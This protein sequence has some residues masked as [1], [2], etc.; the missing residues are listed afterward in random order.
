MVVIGGITRLTG[1]GLSITEWNVIM[2]A[3]PP[4]NA[5]Q[6]Q[7]A[8][9]KYKTIPQ[10]QLI[11][12]HFTLEEFKSIFMWEYL[13]RLIGRLLGVVFLVPFI[14]FL[15]TKKLD[16]KMIRKS[17][18]LF[19]LGG[20][21]GFLGWYM[22]SSGLT[23]RTSVSHYRLAVHLITAFITYG[24]TF[25]FALELIYSRESG[26]GSREKKSALSSLAKLISATVV[27]QI[28]YGAFVAGLH[29]GQIANT[30]PT[31]DGAWVPEGLASM[32]PGLKN[33]FENLL[34]VQFIHRT[35]AV[36]VVALSVW[37]FIA[38][39]KHQLNTSQNK[40]ISFLLFAISVQFVLGVLTLLTKVQIALAAF[41]Q[42]GAFMLFS[43]CVFLLFQFRRTAKV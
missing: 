15:I 11:N 31:M 13:H 33:L 6:W 19:A 8:F 24:F 22:V 27:L 25:W 32:S 21:Q 37:L 28:I 10:Y 16:G 35:L 14:W 41:H 38:S 3:I 29:A 23:E 9:D 43:A 26:V 12:Y 36:I 5:G 34:T 18:F 4:L 2:G 1:S 17:L 7:V 30:W 40:G 42:M 20:L 39:R